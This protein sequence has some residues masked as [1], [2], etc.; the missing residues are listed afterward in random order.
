MWR[1]LFRVLINTGI[2]ERIVI[3]VV[4][5]LLKSRDH[6]MDQPKRDVI[7]REVNTAQQQTDIRRKVKK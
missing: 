5:L 7:V 2:L 1:Q 4:D 3:I 6:E